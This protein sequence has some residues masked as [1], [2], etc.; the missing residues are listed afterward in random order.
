M[1]CPVCRAN[2]EQGPQCRRCRADLGLLFEL[3]E[4]RRQ[5][6]AAARAQLAQGGVERA[7]QFA[8]QADELRH[9]DES[10]RL[11]AVCHVVNG[12]YADAWRVSQSRLSGER[13]E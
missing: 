12:N 6:M 13:G 10:R 5:V 4:Q 3:E 8:A 9:D 7:F 11:L 2:N 1:L